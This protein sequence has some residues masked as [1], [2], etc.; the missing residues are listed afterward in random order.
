[1]GEKEGEF[2]E[3][4]V[5]TAT[6]LAKHV[7]VKA[8]RISLEGRPI[9]QAVIRDITE[10]KEAEASLKKSAQEKEALLKEV[11]HR[12]KNNLQVIMSLLRLEARQGRDPATQAV[13][14]EM[15]GRIRTMALLHEAL[16]LSDNL[17]EIELSGYLRKLVTQL[18][19]AHARET[20]GVRIELEL[21]PVRMEIDRAIPCGLVVNELATNCLKHAFPDGRSGEVRIELQPVAGEP[22]LCLRV[23]DTGVGLPADFELGRSGS[24]GLRLVS[25]L[26]RQLQG[27]LEVSSNGGGAAFSV[28]FPQSKS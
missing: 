20:G 21:A 15:Q 10:R 27:K 24:L 2:L 18:F 14:R 17:A 19:R 22:K 1:M 25:D 26:A 28:T 7:S 5:V 13:L 11:H 9:Q 6:G 12:V 23:S 3:T 16:Y 4:Q 8:N